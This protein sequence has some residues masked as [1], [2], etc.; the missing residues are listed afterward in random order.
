MDVNK[1]EF[2][3]E[4]ESDAFPVG[5]VKW[6]EDS[7]LS[8]NLFNDYNWGGYL[9][10]HLRDR[11]VFVDGRTDLFGDEILEDYLSVIYI[12]DGWEKVLGKYQIDLVLVQDDS[13][14]ASLLRRTGWEIVFEDSNSVLFQR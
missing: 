5:A 1:K 11:P 8:G 6:L 9:I 4:A 13:G 3:L 7:D 10:W 14:L 12:Q 2:V